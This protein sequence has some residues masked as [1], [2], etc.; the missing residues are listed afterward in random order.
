MCKA[1]H[2]VM[3]LMRV[4]LLPL[5]VI[6]LETLLARRFPAHGSCTI[7]TRNA[8]REWHRCTDQ[9]SDVLRCCGCICRHVH[10]NCNLAKSDEM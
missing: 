1:L 7:N 4:G 8:M 10:K 5:N 2:C 3:R 9:A 6:T